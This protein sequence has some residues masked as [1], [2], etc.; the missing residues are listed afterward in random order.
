VNWRSGIIGP[1]LLC[2]KRKT[3]RQAC[4]TRQGIHESRFQNIVGDHGHGHGVFQ[5]DDRY[6]SADVIANSG[7]IYFSA[8]Y[9]ATRLAG[10]YNIYAN[11]GF[12]PDLAI[13]GALRD[14][15]GTGGIPTS[16]ILNSPFPE[17]LDL[18]TAN[19][20]YV[21]SILSIAANCFQ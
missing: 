6:N 5:F 19:S 20:N 16:V 1:L 12:A 10:S 18:G 17:L 14:Y 3:C 2:H 7:N 21:S 11:Q 15:N 9:A 4:A 8:D 13:A